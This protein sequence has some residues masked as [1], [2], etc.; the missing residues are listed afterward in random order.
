[1]PFLFK[2]GLIAS[3][4]GKV[5]RARSRGFD[6]GLGPTIYNGWK[7][8][9]VESLTPKA[10]LHSAVG[11]SMDDQH[12]ASMTRQAVASDISDVLAGHS[13]WISITWDFPP[14]LVVPLLPLGGL[15]YPRQNCLLY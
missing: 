2:G 14:V 8:D 3:F 15:P 11:Y 6:E 7:G 1:M 9:Q 13:F 5:A 4:I 10:I 12:I